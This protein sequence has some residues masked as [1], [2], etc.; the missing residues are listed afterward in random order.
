M[1]F[2]V[3]YSK[4]FCRVY[5]VYDS[6]HH[7]SKADFSLI[8]E[9]PEESKLNEAFTLIHNKESVMLGFLDSKE[10]SPEQKRLLE[11]IPPLKEGYWER[12]LKMFE[13]WAPKLEK[14]LNRIGLNCDA[15]LEQLLGVKPPADYTMAIVGNFARPNILPGQ[16]V[17]NEPFVCLAINENRPFLDHLDVTFHEVMH[18]IIRINGWKRK[19]KNETWEEAFIRL[20]A[21]NGILSERLGIYRSNLDKIRGENCN[22]ELDYLRPYFKEYAV[23]KSNETIFQFL[24]QKKVL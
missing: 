8:L 4:D 14:E 17:S 18:H 13:D 7:N 11:L 24:E 21:P 3:K 16:Q 19:F 10:L 6:I 9:G 12:I 23:N 20:L 15:K 1:H 22:K 5:Q 2:T